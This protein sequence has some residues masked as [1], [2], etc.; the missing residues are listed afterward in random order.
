MA[1]NLA[2]AFL[3]GKVANI[4]DYK[5]KLDDIFTRKYGSST[6]PGRQSII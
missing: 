1:E 3:D 5:Q 6:Q 4:S 2:T